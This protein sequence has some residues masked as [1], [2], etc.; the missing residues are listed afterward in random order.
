MFIAFRSTDEFAIK[1]HTGSVNVV[2][3]PAIR[4]LKA[5]GMMQ[6]YIAV[7]EQRYLDGIRVAPGLIRQFV[8]RP[9]GARYQ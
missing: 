3:G 1:V 2:S 6:D 7:P 5:Y 9:S 8:A 4:G